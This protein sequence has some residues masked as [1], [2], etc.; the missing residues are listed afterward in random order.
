[1][2]TS[3]CMPSLR[4]TYETYRS[5]GPLTPP[6]VPTPPETS[7]FLFYCLYTSMVTKNKFFTF[8]DRLTGLWFPVYNLNLL[9][10]LNSLIV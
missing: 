3:M 9:Y 1:M 4:T 10:V 6:W 8:P 2:I 5:R 7:I